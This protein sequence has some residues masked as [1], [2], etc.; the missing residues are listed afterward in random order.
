MALKAIKLYWLVLWAIKTKEN[1]TKEK[2]FD[3]NQTEM[4]LVVL[5]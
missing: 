4:V 2:S 1:L 5:T 3:S